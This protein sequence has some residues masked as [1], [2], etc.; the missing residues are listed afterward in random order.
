[1]SI[2]PPASASN[3]CVDWLFDP[4]TQL[5]G[6]IFG[7]HKLDENRL[8]IYLLDVCGHGVGAALLSVTVMNV[9]K[10]QSLRDTDFGNPSIV[11]ARLNESF[12]ME[13]HNNMYFT[14]WYGVFDKKN[15]TITYASGGHPPSILLNG[16]DRKSAKVVDLKTNGFLVGTMPGV[17]F[18][19][20]EIK[21]EQFSELYVFSD[22][23]YEISKASDGKLWTFEEWRDLVAGFSQRNEKDL[24]S[25]LKY[26]HE[27]NGSDQLD[28]D[29]SLMRMVL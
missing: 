6:D 27:L 14:I 18:P 17:K 22:G 1:M 24:S 15:R 12:Q 19:S 16:A 20:A 23:T 11:L 9:L 10:N 5:G 25:L 29:F 21:L 26:V 8:V 4:S 3:P 7:Y 13:N 28:D 2:I